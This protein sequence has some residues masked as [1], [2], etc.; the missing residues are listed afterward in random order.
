L[1]K[2]V[3][4]VRARAPK[5][6]SLKSALMDYL[7]TDCTLAEIAAQRSCTIAALMYWATRLGLPG[8]R[9]GRRVLRAPS[10]DDMR[11]IDLVRQFGAAEAARRSG[12]SR[13]RVY[14]ILSRWS[15]ESKRPWHRRDAMRHQPPKRHAAR[16]EIIAFR[17]TQDEWKSLQATKPPSGGSNLSA[18]V[19]AR[20]IVV[21]YIVSPTG[22]GRNLAQDPTNPAP[23]SSDNKIIDFIGRHTA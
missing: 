13:A 12:R 11:V 16:S 2:L 7:T 4:D 21:G 8:R 14:Q 19:K 18:N 22:T 5:Y 3:N 10:A 17:L 6:G 20:S 9:R 1:L 23:K 15:P